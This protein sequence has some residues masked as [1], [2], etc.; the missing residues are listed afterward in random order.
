[1]KEIQTP[2]I[3]QKEES[4][5]NIEAITQSIK[6]ESCSRYKTEREKKKTR[7]HSL[8]YRQIKVKER[9]TQFY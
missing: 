3:K 9:H 4:K 1:M 6:S 2:F 5:I 7:F 8:L